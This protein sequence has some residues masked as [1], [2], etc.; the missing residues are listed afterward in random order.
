M[1]DDPRLPATV[2]FGFEPLPRA[3]PRL[4]WLD[5]VGGVVSVGCAVHCL[6]APLLLL[7]A[8]VLAGEALEIALGVMATGVASLVA[9]NSWRRR[10]DRFVL[11]TVAVGVCLTAARFALD[12]SPVELVLSLVSALAFVTAHVASFR[13]LR[14]EC[15]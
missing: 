2:R 11:I 3:R 1:R 9:L 8:P 12:E 7:V 5:T 4:R 13:A 15:C 6:A 10:R 14:R